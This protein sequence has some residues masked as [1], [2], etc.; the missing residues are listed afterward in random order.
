MMKLVWC[1]ETVVEYK[2]LER[3]HHVLEYIFFWV[4]SP[5]SVVRD[6]QLNSRFSDHKMRTSWLKL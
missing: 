1:M 6:L 2:I 4:V 3:K 5:L